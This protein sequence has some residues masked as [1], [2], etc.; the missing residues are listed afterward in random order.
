MMHPSTMKL[1]DRLCAMTA[2]NKI[3]WAHGETPE[4]LVYDT[5][6]YRV[7]LQGEPTDISLTD[8]SGV[9]LEKVTAADLAQTPHAQGGKYDDVVANLVIDAKR[10][11]RGTE[12]AISTVL[13]GLDLDGDGVVDMP[14]Q[15]GLAPTAEELADPAPDMAED[16]ADESGVA[17]LADA[18]V[19]DVSNAVASLADEVNQSETEKLA[20]SELN[21]FT[22]PE[23][24]HP[25]EPTPED[26]PSAAP[27]AGFGMAGLGAAGLLKAARQA[28]DTPE[29]TAAAPE[30][31]AEPPLAEPTHT[32]ISAPSPLPPR[33]DFNLSSTE[34][35]DAPLQLDTQSP[36]S[37]PVEAAPPP[38]QAEETPAEGGAFVPPK[39]GQILSLSG[40]TNGVA[41][42][43]P[44]MA[45]TATTLS[46]ANPA[47]PEPAAAPTPD[48]IAEPAAQAAPLTAPEPPAPPVEET[49]HD[50]SATP[51]R[52]PASQPANTE[53]QPQAEPDP[54][55]EAVNDTPRPSRFNPWI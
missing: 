16:T 54:E 36:R 40:L 24:P 27:V 6:G 47:M 18:D 39:P 3:E 44:I 30:P 21:G 46:H 7:I 20:A 29:P 32:D 4:S 25:P 9:E 52:A 12:T 2:Q 41:G 37:E 8:S 34:A 5:E 53:P 55:P 49:L 50:L 48:A 51:E 23:P 19:T 15:D 28:P 42:D 31:L 14:M 11:A 33:T 38:P 22:E 45:G 35:S 17:T 1:V 10:H 26:T 13:Q 43:T